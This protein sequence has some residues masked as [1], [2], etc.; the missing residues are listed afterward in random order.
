MDMFK[1][2]KG[3]LTKEELQFIKEGSKDRENAMRNALSL[4]VRDHILSTKDFAELSND[5]EEYSHHAVLKKLMKVL[6]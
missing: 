6:R 1:E 3:Y 2:L 4:L 5:L